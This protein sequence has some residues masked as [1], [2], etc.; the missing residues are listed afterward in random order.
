METEHKP[1]SSPPPRLVSGDLPPG[2]RFGR[3]TIIARLGAGGVGTVYVARD[4]RLGRRVALKMLP[5]AKDEDAAREAVLVEGRAAAAIEHPNVVTIF[6]VGAHDGTP[7]LAMELI[8]GETLRTYVGDSSR[9]VAVHVRWLSEIAAALGA[10]HARG[11]VHGDLKPENVM[12]TRDGAIKVLD[13]GIA[14]RLAPQVDR[15]ATTRTIAPA[16]LETPAAAPA[17]EQA[18]TVFGTPAYMAPEHLR[19]EPID[20]RADVFAWG[21]LAFELLMGE[22]PW[23]DASLTA[24][25]AAILWSEPPPLPDALPVGV[26]SV[27]E[28]ALQKRASD[29]LPSMV[30]V[31]AALDAARAEKPVRRARSAWSGGRAW[32]RVAWILAMGLIAVSAMHRKREEPRVHRAGAPAVAAHADGAMTRNAEAAGAYRAGMQ[33]LRDAAFGASYPNFKRAAQLDPDFAAAHLR[34]AILT[35]VPADA[36]REHFRDATRLRFALSDHDRVLLDSYEPYMRAVPDKVETERRLTAAVERLPPDA[37]LAFFLCWIRFFLGSYAASLDAC[38]RVL[39]IDPQFAAAFWFRAMSLT[40][41]H[42]QS[43][44]LATYAECLHTSPAATACLDDRARVESNDGQ[45]D[46][47]IID[48]RRRIALDPSDWNAYASL[49][50]QMASLGAPAAGVRLALEQAW[51]RR[52]VAFRSI[53]QSQDLALF[54]VFRG[55]LEGAWALSRACEDALRSNDDE[56]DHLPCMHLETK[57][58]LETERPDDAARIATRFRAQRLAWTPFVGGEYPDGR[59]ETWSVE[60]RAGAMTRISYTKLRDSWLAEVSGTPTPVGMQWVAAFASATGERNDALQALAVLS[61]YLPL[62]DAFNRTADID[63][64][65]GRTFLLAGRAAEAVPFL[66]RAAHSCYRLLFGVDILWATLELGEAFEAM[67]S[68]EQAC[69]QYRAVLARV[70]RSRARSH[71]AKVAVSRAN[72]LGCMPAQTAPTSL[73]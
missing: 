59:I 20:A 11:I 27:I 10:A 36:N 62:P 40:A 23:R 50:N 24:L 43:G 56:Y 12:V 47:A 72:A 2:T 61:H 48:A 41:L 58:A 39:E 54:A 1:S 70:T 63:E 16:R 4:E 31:C 38:D 15:S 30:S 9:T 44:A 46:E 13:F 14:R 51:V 68:R 49:A 33:A 35:S 64:P 71:S 7:Y 22:R 18:S 19:G 32:W 57:L 73:E 60:A 65:I 34:Y 28:R 21:V 55:D 66:E 26:R 17:P 6:D 29:R 3:F 42:D 52:D 5:L 69:E 25:V 8:R 37:E 45:C 53:T 67:G